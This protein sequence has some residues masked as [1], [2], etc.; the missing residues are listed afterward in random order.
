[1]ETAVFTTAADIRAAADAYRTAN[2]K[3]RARNVAAGIGVSEAQL[4]ATGV[5][6]NVTVLRPEFGAILSSLEP[7]GRLLALTRND[8]CVHERKG[9]Y[10]GF[11]S[12][13]PHT[14]FVGKDIDL[15]IFLRA[16]AFAFAAEENG[17][18]SL[19]FFDRAGQAVHKVY[20]LDETSADEW[21]TL[22]EQ[23]RAEDQPDTVAGSAAAPR[24]AETPVSDLDLEAFYD[25]WRA[26]GDTHDFFPLLR[27][28]GVSRRQAV[29]N[30][31]ADLVRPVSA[32]ASR[33]LLEGAST[34]GQPIMCFV[35]NDG[36]IQIHTGGVEKIV[37]HGPWINVLDEAFN[38]HLDETKIAES[39]VV[40]KP[41]D[42]G[43]V[44]ALEVFDESGELIVQFFGARKPGLPERDDWRAL[45]ASLR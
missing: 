39:Y 45:A 33:L 26:L 34:T 14:L 37:E 29:R 36:C 30:A 2:P 4:L 18:R 11:Q 3:A 13:G 40:T 21:N 38:L 15:R 35:G 32:K 12:Q 22:V 43:D 7:L 27:K 31:P 16:W 10:S 42:T 44:T 19:Q 5:G 28:H 8:A 23:F 1:M 20:A 41:G 24:P 6:T 9:V 25:G 17:R